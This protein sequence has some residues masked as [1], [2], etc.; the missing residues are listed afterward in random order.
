MK[1]TFKTTAIATVVALAALTGSSA[2][3]QN[4]LYGEAALVV[5]PSA[6]G[7]LSR[8]DVAADAAVW[9][10]AHQGEGSSKVR[11]GVGIRNAVAAAP[12]PA[13]TRS[14]VRSQAVASARAHQ[15]EGSAS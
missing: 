8:A 12:A 4:N 3:A 11:P 9:A 7:Q 14:E 5:V 1:S 15:T 10:Q 6:T 2:F 13:L